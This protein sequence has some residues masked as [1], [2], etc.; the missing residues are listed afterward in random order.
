MK[1]LFTLLLA[2]YGAAAL[3]QRPSAGPPTIP[4]RL[5][6][7]LKPLDTAPSAGLELVLPALQA[8]GIGSYG[9]KFPH[10]L[11]PDAEHP[12]SV[13]LRRIFQLEVPPTLSLPKARAVLLSTGAVEYVEPLY[14]RQPLYQPN[15]PL[16]DS[17]AKHAE[18]YLSLTK[19]YQAWNVTQGDT[20]IVIGITDTGIRYTHE[21]LRHQVK[22]NYADPINGVDDDGDGYIDNFHGWDVAN[23][24][25]DPMY[26]QPDLHGSQVTGV[27]SAQADNGK[28]GAGTGFKCKFLPIQVFPG[29]TTGSFAGFEGIVYAADHGCQ[30][31]N[32]SWGGAGGHSQFEQDVCTYAAVN[33][34]AVLVAAAGNTPADLDFYPASYDYVLSVANT[35]QHD[36]KEVTATYSHRVDL[37]APGVN[38]WTVYGGFSAATAAA[39]PP[40]ADYYIV[41]TGS[42]FAA[43]QVAGAAALV[44]ARF[45]QFT[46][47]QVQAQLRR[48]TDA[49]LY[50]LPGN[51]NYQGYLGTG[52]LNVARAVAG[53]ASYEARIEGSSFAPAQEAYAPGDT[54][55]LAVAVRNLLLP[56]TGLAVTL[57][58]DSPYL[59]V[60]QGSYTVGSLA[61]LGEADNT[62]TPF[63][64]AIAAAAPPNTTA[65]LRYHLTSAEGFAADQY[66]QVLLNADYVQL[67]AGDMALSLSSA[68]NFGYN[69]ASGTVGRSVTY[70]QGPP[71]LSEGGLLL[72]T[73]PTRVSDNLRAT[74]SIRQSFYTL[75]R[76][77]RLVPGPRAD[78]EAF[79]TFRDS[80]PDPQRPRSVG[81]RVRQ[82]GQSWASPAARRNFVL[83]DYTLRN[84]TAD[85]LKPLYA[86]LFTDWDLPGNAGRNVVRWDS[87]M[88]LS[89]CYDPL[90]P[91]VYTGVQLLTPGPTGVYAI[92]NA[93]P[94]TA[95]I[96]LHNGFSIAE[97]YLAVSGGFSPD[98]RRLGTDSTGT[99]VST[100]VAARLAALAPADSATV[101]FAVLAAPDLP[102]LRAAALE[103]IAA[104]QQA[105]QP[106]A[107][108]PGAAGAGWQLYPNP[109]RDRLHVQ[110]PAAFGA[111]RA[112][113][114]DA[115]GRVVLQVELPD[116]GG[117]LDL[118]EFPAGLY[119]LRLRGDGGI[120]ARRVVR[121]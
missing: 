103:A 8:L 95:P 88:R 108:L 83:L 74:S 71:L 55:H 9:Q 33:R 23:D 63:R 67:D 72:A 86:G 13:D 30:V 61:T 31:I 3:A 18:Y 21:D 94:S 62:A 51:A 66:V 109:T 68:G 1:Y 101:T 118:R 5:V 110:L 32:M 10:A 104:Y 53:L 98:H 2:L 80:L 119:V 85:T 59:V 44:R 58:S 28:G 15:D 82:H 60:R 54:L 65:T 99:D 37:T 76:A 11:P 115:L 52:R 92:D 43:P 102:T 77:K 78:Q 12:G 121:E 84:L 90:V 73:T 89:Y 113:L 39:G 4:G 105:Q 75:A 116:G 50:A 48:T 17:T 56:Q 24:N 35:D 38:L 81:V 93:E 106:L 100:V 64:L 96:S 117:E 120:L 107:T 20:N 91:R 41:Y 57:T 114:L 22:Y 97:K 47:Q 6:M 36:V 27:V 25:N 46:A 40:D 42:S 69:D 7:K 19:T 14:V 29:T 70:K 112:E 16:A 87:T 111:A 26:N 79:G 49:D 34:D 45:P